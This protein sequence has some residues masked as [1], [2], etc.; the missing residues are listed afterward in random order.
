MNTGFPKTPRWLAALAVAGLLA[1]CASTAQQQTTPAE[2]WHSTTSESSQLP[3]NI[4][5]F[6]QQAPE[7]GTAVF[8]QSPWGKQA[9]LRI[10]SRYFAG[11]GR[12][13][14]RLH[15]APASKRGQAAI[16]CKQ[17]SQ[18]VPV[19]PVTQ[20]LNNRDRG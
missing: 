2:Q 1:G 16:A 18:W 14:V 10:E 6:L 11:S 19:R 12:E 20:L 7:Q 17:N 13:C 9:E 15:V 3:Q 4:Q 8:E 5:A